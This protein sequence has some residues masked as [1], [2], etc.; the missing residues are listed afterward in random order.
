VTAL[1]GVDRQGND[2]ARDWRLAIGDFRLYVAMFNAY[3]GG[4]Q[5]CHCRTSGVAAVRAML[6]VVGWK[7]WSRKW[8][9]HSFVETPR[10]RH[11]KARCP[12]LSACGR[13]IEHAIGQY[14]KEIALQVALH[15]VVAQ[16]EIALLHIHLQQSPY[17]DYRASLSGLERTRG[18]CYDLGIRHPSR[19]KLRSR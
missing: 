17:T 8:T 2:N 19:G 6:C 10:R 7:R 9:G 3:G 14:D 15:I 11:G 4:Y 1:K 5:M 13:R 18:Q 16:S 12:R